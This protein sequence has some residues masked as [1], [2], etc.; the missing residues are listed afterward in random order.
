MK[1]RDF[2][3]GL[4]AAALLSGPALAQD[5]VASVI[6]QLERMGFR[7]IRQERTLLGRVRI[8][9]TRRDGRREIII[10]PNNGEILRDLWSPTGS[11]NRTSNIIEDKSGNSGS[12]SGGDDDDDDDDDDGGSDNSGSGSSNSGSGGGDDDDDSGGDDDDGD[13]GGDDDD[14]D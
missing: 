5:Y 2:M 4:G 11:G 14:D 6:S 12:G 7:I 1:R 3:S 8:V 9:G 13:D 10:N